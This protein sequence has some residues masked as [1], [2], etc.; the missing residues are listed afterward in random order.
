MA[1]AAFK[2]LKKQDGYKQA[3]IWCKEYDV[4][5]FGDSITLVYKKE[6]AEDGTLPALDSYQQVSHYGR[7]YDDLF[8]IHRAGNDHPKGRTF[9]DRVRGKHG[10]CIPRSA[11]KAFTERWR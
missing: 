2:E 11:C 10:K 7:L 3:D 5:K 8:A 6:A 1:P 9:A 4:M